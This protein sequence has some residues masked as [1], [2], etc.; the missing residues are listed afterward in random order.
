MY[1]RIQQALQRGANDEALTAAREA[2]ASAGDDPQA[3]RMLSASLAASGDRDGALRSL[4]RAL[5][6][7]PDD[8]DLHFQRAGL[9]LGAGDIAA[10]RTALSRT[11]E[12]DPN[13]FGAY[14]LQAQ[15]ALGRGDLVEAERLQRLARR[16]APEHVWISVIE[17]ML[18]LRRGDVARAQAVLSQAA[19]T[20]PHDVQVRYA[21][22]F[23]YMADGRHAFAEQAFRGVAETMSEG[24]GLH[25]L[26]AELLRRQGRHADAAEA[27]APMLA[28][29]GRATPG[30][31]RFAGELHLQAGQPDRA[32]P[33]LRSAL[34]EQPRD[35]RTL[36]AAVQ[37]WLQTKAVDE[38]RSALDAAVVKAPD[39]P[40][41]WRARL[42]FEQPSGAQTLAVMDR[43]LEAMP[44]HLPALEAKM[45]ALARSQDSEA[46][47]GIARRIVALHPGH[48]SAELRLID[49]KLQADPAQAV[50]HLQ[51]L[52]AR[53]QSDQNAR[54]LRA[55]LGIAHDRAGDFQAAA[56]V[57]LRL[58]AD[59]ASARLPL[60]E[61]TDPMSDWPVMATSE[62]GPAIAFL[63]GLPGS[64]VEQLAI[65]LQGSVEAFRSDRFGASPPADA[66][67][68]YRSPQQL[69]GGEMS[70]ST[71]VQT[72]RDGLPRRGLAGGEIIDWLLWWDNA[73][74]HALRP[75]LPQ[76]LI[77]IALRDPRDMLLDWLAF[78][79]PAPLRMESATLAAQ[80]LARGLEHIAVLVEGDLFPHRLL[81]LDECGNDPKGLAHMLSGALE[82]PLPAPP[83]EALGPA[84]F[85]PGHWRQYRDAL[86]APFALLAPLAVRLG[87]P[88]T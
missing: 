65:V 15:L 75:Q 47:N 88:E 57:W 60:P 68:N 70:A 13:E 4:E 54:L 12:L 44:D 55:W 48:G 72:W 26:I 39:H 35:R 58:Q 62:A 87:Y 2:V 34:L 18:A 51:D 77:L 29:A 50:A 27:L 23:A 66:L 46:A 76:G 32:L 84:H 45:V 49:A 52:L 73:F 64:R 20:A 24:H 11:S 33:L 61:L 5:E 69:L 30:L 6:L 28:D 78:G 31:R 63:A 14:I 19:E 25:A 10:A 59:A 74:L 53:A 7:A 83:A 16:I 67:Q 21:L 8:A 42:A 41:L 85:P 36:D 80:W 40:D 56:A 79:A 22:G 71:L 81:R 17:G 86:A 38:G 3:H 43:W 1:E 37:A 82:T 9:L